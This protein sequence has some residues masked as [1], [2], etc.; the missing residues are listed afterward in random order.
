M[1]EEMDSVPWAPY[2]GADGAD[3]YYWH[4]RIKSGDV[5]FSYQAKKNDTTI[6]KYDC[7]PDKIPPEF[8]VDAPW[9]YE[10]RR[11]D[12]EYKDLVTQYS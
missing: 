7:Y 1:K 11:V 10:G 2:E 5:I 8:G 3:R 12:A 6:A 4:G 9:K